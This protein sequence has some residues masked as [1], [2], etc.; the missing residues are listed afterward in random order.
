[1]E[2]ALRGG[3]RQLHVQVERRDQVRERLHLHSRRVNTTFYISSILRAKYTFVTKSARASPPDKQDGSVGSFVMC[4]SSGLHFLSSIVIF[5]VCSYT[6]IV[7]H[8]CTGNLCRFAVILA[9]RW[10]DVIRWDSVSS[11]TA[12]GATRRFTIH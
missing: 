11:C 6:G 1:M 3:V 8:F 7:A 10:S 4:Y 5:F 2:G 9:A 12:G